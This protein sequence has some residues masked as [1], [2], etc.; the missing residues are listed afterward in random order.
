MFRPRTNQINR[1]ERTVTNYKGLTMCKM[2]HYECKGCGSKYFVLMKTR[3]ERWNN[4]GRV[5]GKKEH[6]MYCVKCNLHIRLDYNG[7]KIIHESWQRVNNK[8]MNNVAY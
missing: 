7:N 1:P 6:Y 8:V 5:W 3:G 2:P 4:M